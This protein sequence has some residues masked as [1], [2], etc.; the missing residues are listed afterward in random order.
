ME[1]RINTYYN[2]AGHHADD[3]WRIYRGAVGSDYFDI[4]LGIFKRMMD[5]GFHEEGERERPSGRDFT[6]V[7]EAPEISSLAFEA[8]SPPKF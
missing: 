5:A 3:Y 6:I 4:I 7:G 2:V 1:A 8:E